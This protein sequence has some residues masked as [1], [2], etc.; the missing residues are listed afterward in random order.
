MTGTPTSVEQRGGSG[1]L[2][3]ERVREDFPVLGQTV[4][5]RP[6]VY[7]DSAAT[8][9]K[10]R[11]VI[12]AVRSFYEEYNSNVH[13][14]V[15]ALSQHATRAYEGARKKMRRFLN[16]E[17][18]EELVF[19]RGT[20]EAMNLVA[21]SFARPRLKPGDEVLVTHM[22]HHSGIVPWQ[23]VCEET[24]AELKV[25][26]IDE[27]GQLIPEELEK[28]LSERTKIVSVVH[29]SNALGTVNPV[30]WIAERAHEKGATVVVDGA[31]GAPHMAVDVQ[32]LGCDFYALSG[33]KMFGPS[34]VGVLY[35]R[36]ELLEAMPPY[37]GGGEMIKSVTFE[38]TLYDDP[39]QKFE[40]GTPNIAGGIGLGAA[41]D[42]LEGIGMGT[43]EAHEREL[44]RYA[45]EAVGAID[46][47]ELVGTAD[48][49]AGV[50]S[51][52][53]HAAHPHDIG[54][55]VDAQG[56]AIRTGHHCTQPLM[57]R[58]GVAAT[59]RASF[60]LY[61]THEEVDTLVRAIQKVREV[62]H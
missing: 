54:T 4:N 42:Y 62:F 6:V 41:V 8:S 25:A 34:G 15:H 35:G 55:I 20:T 10:P 40:A 31:Q 18:T 57:E 11:Q 39:P 27:R 49:K 7:L 12:D 13:R 32:E 17:R 45:S 38:K 37:Q 24:G 2:D 16:A 53:M 52:V 28:R 48:V 59:A 43:V 44:V 26:P 5:G 36:S 61:N 33:H 3:V 23:M 56:V 50:V 22:E 30:K 14:G 58:F 9:Q 46:G 21:Q 47:V 19:V 29:V 51:F 60:A 1:P